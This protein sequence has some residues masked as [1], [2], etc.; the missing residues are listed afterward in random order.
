MRIALNLIGY[1]PGCGGVET[2]IINL[3]TALQCADTENHYLVLCDDSAA[4]SLLLE[5]DNFHLKTVAYQKY[6]LKGML[7]GA[8]LRTAG[9]DILVRE[10]AGIE[11]DVMHHPLTILNP[12][13]LSYPSVLTFHDMQQEYFPEFFSHKELRQRRKT[14]QSSVQEAN[15]VIAVSAH[16]KNCLVEKYDISPLKVHV[17]Y[18][19]CGNEFYV[20]EPA[21]LSKTITT[22]SLERPF[23]F[24]PAATWPHKNHVRLLEALKL[25]INQGSFDGE[26]LLTG[27]QKN[28]HRDVNETIKRLRLEAKVRWLGYLPQNVIPQLY[29]LARLMVFPSLFEGFGLPVIEAMASG[30]PVVCSQNSS[31]PEVGGKAAVY[32]DPLNAEDIAEKISSVW[33]NDETREKIRQEGLLQAAKFQW[34]IT[35]KNTLAVYRRVRDETM[36]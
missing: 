24:Y 28:A 9:Y 13:G 34:E 22:F 36:I 25:L 11:V 2:Y 30:C 4:S 20:R 14:Y 35:A 31:L 12:A 3:L 16:A 6:S 29:N 18:S 1:S 33:S 15:A 5:A 7:R 23:M 27:A 26:L 32:F 19:G 21:S 8:L 10:L 17:V